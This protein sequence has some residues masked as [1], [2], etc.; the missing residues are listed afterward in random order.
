MKLRVQLDRV[1]QF[2][3]KRVDDKQQTQGQAQRG[4]SNRVAIY[5]RTASAYP[6]RQRSL[7]APLAL[8]T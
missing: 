3:H 7:P 1:R 2:R 4:W 5:R 8:F 6:L